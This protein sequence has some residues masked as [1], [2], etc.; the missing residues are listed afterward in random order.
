MMTD[1]V[2]G[3]IN[4]FSTR[5]R[6]TVERALARSGRYEDMIRRTLARRGSAAGPDLPG[7]GRVR[8]PPPGR[9]PRRRQRHVAVHG[10]P[11]PRLR[12]GAQLV[13]RRPPGPRKSHKRR[14]PPFKRPLQRVR[15]LVPRHGRLQLRPRH[16]PERG[17]AHRLR[18]FLGTLPPQRA[19]Q[20]NAQLRPHH[21]GRHHHGQESRAIRPG[22]GGQGKSR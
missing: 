5:G 3:F 9:L 17:Q 1:Q 18:R 13:G 14:R 22:F 12:S 10:Q 16:S 2:A 4:Y 11:R 8:I 20:R 21:S 7:P 15:R 6:G 19:A